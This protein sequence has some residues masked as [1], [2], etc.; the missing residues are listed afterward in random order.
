MKLMQDNRSLFLDAFNVQ[1]EN[2]AD[3]GAPVNQQSRENLFM[4]AFGQDSAKKD[5]TA[6]SIVDYELNV[7][8]G[9]PSKLLLLDEYIKDGVQYAELPVG[10]RAL[11]KPKRPL[12]K[13][14]RHQEDNTGYTLEQRQTAF[15]ALQFNVDYLASLA[16]ADL[17]ASMIHSEY[18]KLKE[19]FPGEAVDQSLQDTHST[20]LS[21]VRAQET[22]KKYNETQSNQVSVAAEIKAAQEALG[23]QHLSANQVD[24]AIRGSEAE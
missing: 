21:T 2:K 17:P 11:V 16:V 13:E 6:P 24:S 20:V 18:L 15:D 8:K 7:A 19:K 23:L 5:Y 3:S 1:H 14:L 4:L 12:A 10:L 9:D 22:A